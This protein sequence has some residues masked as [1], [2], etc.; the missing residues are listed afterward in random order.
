[1]EL[2]ET[3]KYLPANSLLPF[4]DGEV[5]W[6]GKVLNVTSNS[7]QMAVLSIQMSLRGPWQLVGA[8][9]EQAKPLEV[10]ALSGVTYD[11]M[12][13]A[14]ALEASE[15]FVLWDIMLKEQL[16]RRS[17]SNGVSLTTRM[18]YL[19]RG[20]AGPQVSR[21]TINRHWRLC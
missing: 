5:T 9:F 16:L 4:W 10:A 17:A 7:F 2:F 19:E 8:K 1:M 3:K 20:S 11:G 14:R 6:H 18:G 13:N 21:T 12:A 15:S